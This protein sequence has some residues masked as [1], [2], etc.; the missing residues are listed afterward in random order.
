MV[1]ALVI[2]GVCGTASF[3]Y[4]KILFWSLEFF[5]HTLPQMIV[6]DKWPEWAYVFWI[7]LVGFAMA[8]GVGLTVVYLGE[9][10]DL[11]YTV[12]CVHER[13][14]VAMSHVIPMVS[15]KTPKECIA[16]SRFRNSSDSYDCGIFTLLGLC[17]AIQHCWWGLARTGGSAS[18]DLR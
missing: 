15:T 5:W 18:C 8:L 17:I 1:L 12:K 3:V 10:G 7:P 14:Y 4:Y 9:P 13:A 16:L 6:V 2:G 11:P